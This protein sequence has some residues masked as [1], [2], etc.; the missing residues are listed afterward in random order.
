M[1]I[2]SFSEGYKLYRPV[3]DSRVGNPVC[4]FFRARPAVSGITFRSP[5]MSLLE[6]MPVAAGRHLTEVVERLPH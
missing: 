4:R 3:A 6:A 1:A 2:R 5:A